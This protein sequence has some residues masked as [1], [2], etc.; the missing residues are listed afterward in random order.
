MHINKS[1]QLEREFHRAEKH[2]RLVS[3]LLLTP[4]LIFILV[5]F[6]G[7]I[8]ALL[9]RAVQSVEVSEGLP[10]TAAHII[11]WDGDKLPDDR[12][13]E[14]ITLDL[15]NSE[16]RTKRASAARRLNYELPGYRTLIMRTARKLQSIDLT[17]ATDH[18][19]LL[20]ELDQR[21]GQREYWLAL[22]RATPELTPYYL[23][24][25]LDMKVDDDN[26]I[27]R[28]DPQQQIFIKIILRSLWIAFVVTLLCFLIAYPV[29]NF[30]LTASPILR[31]LTLISVLLPFWTSLLVRTSAWIVILQREG[32]VNQTLQ[33]L[34]ITDQPLELIFNRFG[35]YVSMIH[36]LLP[37]MILPIYSVMKGIPPNYLRA[38]NSLGAHPVRAFFDIY[39]PLTLPGV[40]AGCLLTFIVGVGYYITPALVGGAQDQMVGYFI[41]FFTNVRLNWGMASSLSIFLLICI[42][43]LYIGLGRFIGISR[44]AGLEK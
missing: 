13:F 3:W 39:F 37:F 17:T 33:F 9:L 25:A 20:I 40:G 6:I 44:L 42:L 43:S 16:T 21:W 4:L 38:A 24:A 31:A 23:L 1:N 41:A 26:S 8:G 5:V 30:M 36:I 18:R 15:A 7:P 22:K 14:S 34:T 28:A 12:F 2:Q 11:E 27:A 32:M 29:A 19:A 35:V 10:Q